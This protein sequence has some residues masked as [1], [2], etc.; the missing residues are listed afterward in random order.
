[1]GAGGRDARAAARVEPGPGRQRRPR[2]GR[3][4]RGLMGRPALTLPA[5]RLLAL[6]A[7]LSWAPA[8]LGQVDLDEPGGLGSPGGLAPPGQPPARPG[9]G[10]AKPPET[11]AASGAE[12]APKLP[13]REPSLP[14]QP[15]E[16]PKPVRDTIG[17]NADA[18]YERGR[19]PETERQFYGLWY[20]ERSGS[21]QF[22]TAFPFW[23]ERRQE[24]DRASLFGL[25]YYNR[26]SP[27]QDADILFPF[28]WRLRN[29]D[30]STWVVPPVVHSSSPRGHHN[31]VAPLFFEGADARGGGY[32]HIPAL[33]TFTLHSERSGFSM[34]GPLYCKWKG[35]SACDARTADDID[36]GLA[37]LYFYG[38]N[39]RREYEVIPPLLHY[40]EYE[41]SGERSLNVWGPL[42]L[43]RDRKGG[44]LDVLPLYWQSWGENEEHYT[45]LP[46]FH[47]GYKGASN[48]LVTPLFLNANAED[49]AHTF[50]TW[51][52]ARHRGRTEL[53]MLSPLFWWYRDPDAGLDRKL[54]F[55]LYYQESSPRSDDLVL[56][57]F[58]GRFHRRNVS[59]S[60]WVTPLFR[61]ETSLTGWETSILP[62]FHVGRSDYSTHFVVAP[63]LWDFASPKKRSTVF[64]PVYWRF[65]D[66]DSVH[67]L[68]GNTYYRSERVAGGVD[69]EFHFFP[70]FSYGE[71]PQ[72]HWWNVLYG[73][74]G[75][76][77][78]GTMSKMR[79]AYL[80]FVLSK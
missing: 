3:G 75:Y 28:F 47:Y 78:D 9:P 53:D 61:H 60:F 77:Q 33:L 73:L 58:Y 30:T 41:E 24:N 20:A 74:A 13:T 69:W 29:D 15:I 63:L 79:I 45:L 51:G 43:E 31:W 50:V 59:D 22:R 66:R 37:P 38:R 32:L 4:G 7:V 44:V 11:H 8:A 49:G 6:C 21:Y 64:F 40:Y 56:F 71:T 55:P 19:A 57:P 70:A 35:G 72:G 10:G 39:D 46:L 52:Y 16:I 62:L 76:T 23:A 17:T 2:A 18:D 65:A 36:L 54:L 80:P 48:L 12:E 26:R 67:Q 34:V 25:S 5:A 1:M 42:W 68:I 14:E 27:Q